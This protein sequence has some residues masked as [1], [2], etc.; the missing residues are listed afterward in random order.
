MCAY[1]IIKWLSLCNFSKAASASTLTALILVYDLPSLELL[2]SVL[3]LTL[4]RG[5]SVSPADL[6]GQWKSPAEDLEQPLLMVQSIGHYQLVSLR[7]FS[8]GFWQK[9]LEMLIP[10]PSRYL[11]AHGFSSFKEFQQMWGPWLVFAKA[12]SFTLHYI[13]LGICQFY[14][15]LRSI[16]FI[17]PLMERWFSDKLH[18]V[19]EFDI[20]FFQ[21]VIS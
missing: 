20:F 21:I 12:V 16:I 8:G 2:R 18:A 1:V 9:I 4:S 13:Y 5:G 17:I 14:H 7:V 15:F 11:Q 10:Y 19:A 6:W 3:A